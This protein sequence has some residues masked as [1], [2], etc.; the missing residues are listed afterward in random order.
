[1][2]IFNTY[3]NIKF[4][5]R[6]IDWNNVPIEDLRISSIHIIPLIFFNQYHVIAFYN[7]YG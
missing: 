5:D 6:I 2:N 1:M 3:D 4:E 7:M